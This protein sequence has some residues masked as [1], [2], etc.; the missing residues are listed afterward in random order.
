MAQHRPDNLKAMAINVALAAIL[1][2]SL[3]MLVW[4][5]VTA[6]HIDDLIEKAVEARG[7]GD[8][9]AFEGYRE[10]GRLLLQFSHD[11]L[12]WVIAAY[13]GVAFALVALLSRWM[14]KVRTPAA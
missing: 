13:F 6:T 7:A 3:A 10:S 14:A 5:R 2:G 8:V 4:A 1:A 11:Q 12:P 9:S